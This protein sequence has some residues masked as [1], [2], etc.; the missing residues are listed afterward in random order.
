[1]T[2]QHS[3]T[4][5]Y[6]VSWCWHV[7]GHE[8]SDPLPA[9][10]LVTS[11]DP[12]RHFI[13]C[14]GKYFQVSP[15]MVY[16]TFRSIQNGC[17][18]T[19]SPLWRRKHNDLP[20]CSYLSSC[21]ERIHHFKNMNFMIPHCFSTQATCWIFGIGK[22]GDIGHNINH[23]HITNGIEGHDYWS[24]HMWGHPFCTILNQDTTFLEKQLLLIE[25]K[26]QLFVQE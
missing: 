5:C 16:L 6:W 10:D 17:S 14:C 2:G 19:S 15:C 13:T 18:H 21:E 3:C 20:C 7:W 12:L 26:K 8:P 9:G 1:M 24:S 22:A 11:L 4:F 25:L 23:G